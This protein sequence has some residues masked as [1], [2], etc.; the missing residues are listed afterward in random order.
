MQ[1]PAPPAALSAAHH[2]LDAA[3][4]QT[5]GPAPGMGAGKGMS[6]QMPSSVVS[7]APHMQANMGGK[8][9]PQQRVM[10]PSTGVMHQQQPTPNMP[11]NM[12]QPNGAQVCGVISFLSPPSSI[13]FPNLICHAVVMSRLLGADDI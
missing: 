1:A 5:Q 4:K 11:P 2:A 7:S 8:P 9:Q 13:L 6:Q 3:R 12:Q 10:A